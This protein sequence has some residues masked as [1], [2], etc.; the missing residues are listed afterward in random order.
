M[1]IRSEL[2]EQGYMRTRESQIKASY[3]LPASL[4]VYISRRTEI[5]VGRN[6]RQTILS[7]LS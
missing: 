1:E 5:L 6:N 3:L 2:I 4:P 7:R